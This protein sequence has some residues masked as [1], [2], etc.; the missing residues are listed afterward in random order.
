LR[1]VRKSLWR[2]ARTV[3]L[4]AGVGI[5]SAFMVNLPTPASASAHVNGKAAG[6][7]VP[8]SDKWITLGATPAPEA[9]RMPV[10]ALE[11]LSAPLGDKD[12]SKE[13]RKARGIEQ[14]SLGSNGARQSGLARS[15]SEGN[16][17]WSAS[18]S[19]L[20]AALR[21]VIAEVSAH[22]GG[23]TVNST[24]RSHAHNASVG[25]AP[26]SKHLSGDAVDFKIGGN[27][28]SVL[29]FLGGHRSV[30]GL[31]HY[32]DGHIHI[33]TGPRRTW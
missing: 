14:A 2:H 5:S 18:A 21:Q 28:R 24:C 8:A 7:V 31:K 12:A 16:V 32:A 23:V 9:Q 17:H 25:G 1:K 3:A 33:D 27:L 19:C 15:L 20:N 11:Q 4:L 10:A 22:F 13:R 29:A 6:D 26:H 30:G